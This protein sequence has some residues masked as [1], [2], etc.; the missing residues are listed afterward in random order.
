[1]KTGYGVKGDVRC[2]VPIVAVTYKQ[3]PRK[4]KFRGCEYACGSGGKRER[5]E[6]PLHSVQGLY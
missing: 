2:P 4:D 3:R 1:M 5:G 6:S